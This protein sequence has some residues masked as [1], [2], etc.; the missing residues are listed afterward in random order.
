MKKLLI[1]LSLGAS[2]LAVALAQG[3]A[4]AQ[5]LKALIATA[6]TIVN[7]LLPLSIGLAVI[8]FFF[9]L[10]MFIVKGREGAEHAKWL[11]F[12][13]MSILALFVMVSI[14][15]LVA[16]IGGVFNIT[17][18]GAAPRIDIPTGPTIN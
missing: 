4:P 14:W 2:T 15:G 12:M 11:Q 8:A 16:F 17:S 6:Q 13:G 18:G 10:V 9:G 3:T 7:Q 1:T 5:N